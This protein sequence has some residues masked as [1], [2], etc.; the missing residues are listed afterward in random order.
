MIIGFLFFES[1]GH[2]TRPFWIDVTTVIVVGV[3]PLYSGIQL[4]RRRYENLK[5]AM[6]LICVGGAA[7]FVLFSAIH[8]AVPHFAAPQACIIAG[9]GF[10]AFVLSGIVW[11]TAWT[12]WR[13]RQRKRAPSQDALSCRHAP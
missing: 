7:A 2:S 5:N 9:E 4:L 10:I 11:I 12:R 8:L 6:R 13:S 3:L 1:Q